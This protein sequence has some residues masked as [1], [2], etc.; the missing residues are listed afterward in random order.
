MNIP[1]NLLETIEQFHEPSIIAISGFGGSGKSTFANKLGEQIHAPIIGIDEFQKTRARHAEFSDWSVMDFERLKREVL[2]PFLNGRDI[3]YGCFDPATD[4]ISHTRTIEHTKF[5]IIEGV[6]L[7]RPE[8]MKYFAYTIWIDVPIERAIE[9]GKK[10]DREEYNNPSDEQWDGIW[11]ENDV[12]Y[13]ERY[14]PRNNADFIFN[15]Q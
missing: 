5:L 8:L 12:E 10:R 1:T 2:E 3:A 9:Q 7:F 4:A 14:S 6:G 11:R 15:N 13:F